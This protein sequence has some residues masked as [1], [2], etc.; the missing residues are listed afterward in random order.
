MKPHPL[1]P[2][3]IPLLALAILAAGIGISFAGTAKPLNILVLGSGLGLARNALSGFFCGIGRTQVV[4]VS[5]LAATAVNAFLNW[6]LIFGHL[7]APPLGVVGAGLATSLTNLLLPVALF[8]WIRRAR[9]H[10]A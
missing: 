2:S 9:L 10:Q 3:T 6:V 1:R 7:G 4:M 8:V 5:A